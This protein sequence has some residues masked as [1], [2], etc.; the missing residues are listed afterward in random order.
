M[1]IDKPIFV[2]GRKAILSHYIIRGPQQ[3]FGMVKF[4]DGSMEE[5]F[6][7]KIKF[8]DRSS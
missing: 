2:D 6:H 7:K 5:V 1:G 3:T 8:E 4:E